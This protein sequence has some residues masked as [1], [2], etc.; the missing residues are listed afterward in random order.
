[1]HTDCIGNHDVSKP[2]ETSALNPLDDK[3]QMKCFYSV[4]LQKKWYES[5]KIKVTDETPSHWS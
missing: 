2:G 4:K 3:D 5:D 1:M